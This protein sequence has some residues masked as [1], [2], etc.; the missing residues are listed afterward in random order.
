MD[1]F[2]CASEDLSSPDLVMTVAIV[3][4][5][6]TS[7]SHLREALRDTV[8]QKMPK[9]GARITRQGKAYDFNIPTSFSDTT[10]PFIFTSLDVSATL[11]E[12]NVDLPIHAPDSRIPCFMPESNIV[13]LFRGP[14]CPTS[15]KDFLKPNVPVLHVHVVVHSDATLIG[16]TTTHIAFD[17]HGLKILLSAWA[18]ATRRALRDIPPA[19]PAFHPLSLE[20]KQKRLDRAAPLSQHEPRR[21]WYALGVFGIIH[22]VVLY[23]W[24]LLKDSEERR[25]F[26]R[27]PKERV[28]QMKEAAME[29][30]KARGEGEWVSTNDIVAAWLLKLVYAHR[31]D[32]TPIALHMT[33]NL[34]G[35]LPDVFSVPYIN[36]AVATA[37]AYTV[38]ANVLAGQ[39]LID[40]ALT[41][42]RALLAYKEDTTTLYSEMTDDALHPGRTLFPCHPGEQFAIVNS[43]LSAK[44]HDLAFAP[45]LGSSKTVSPLWVMPYTQDRSPVP[46]RAVLAIIFES[47]DSIW[48]RWALGRKDLRR[49]Q[50]ALL[51]QE[52]ATFWGC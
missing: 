5:A 9:A 50:Q 40:T 17:A 28:L 42:R 3:L 38:P 29:E 43:W 34:R 31:R 22:F 24:S 47:D 1:V 6:P 10:P 39:P 4:S 21:G 46:M 35:L 52:E 27:I 41:L 12:A 15:L 20:E 25:V 45:L 33:I 2:S 11:A 32:S 30:L 37:P 26:I 18:S 16:I 44:Y 49:M 48:A 14:G 51:S 7:I 23:V 19:P 36:N 8:V 13:R